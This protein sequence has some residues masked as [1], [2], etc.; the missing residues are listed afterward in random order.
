[1]PNLRGRC[2]NASIGSGTGSSRPREGGAGFP[3]MMFRTSLIRK[4]P[5]GQS[6]RRTSWGRRKECRRHLSD[7]RRSLSGRRPWEARASSPG[8]MGQGEQSGTG[9]PFSLYPESVAEQRE[10]GTPHLFRKGFRDLKNLRIAANLLE[11]F[12][13]GVCHRLD[14]AIRTVV[15]DED[16][17]SHRNSSLNRSYEYLLCLASRRCRELVGRR[18]ECS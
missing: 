4:E 7:P 6:S 5:M 11:A 18:R 12:G 2:S 13:D 17:G 14:M 1:M 8:P 10:H 3:V 15:H 16:L 9:L